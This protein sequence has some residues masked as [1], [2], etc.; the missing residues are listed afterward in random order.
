MSA[1]KPFASLK[2]MPRITRRSGVLAQ[3]QHLLQG[4]KRREIEVEEAMV[5]AQW[6]LGREASAVPE[7][8][9]AFADGLSHMRRHPDRIPL[10][11]ETGEGVAGRDARDNAARAATPNGT[12]SPPM[13]L[14]VEVWRDS[15]SGMRRVRISE[16]S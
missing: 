3:L 4:A 12:T 8:M 2:R 11:T 5:E 6:V 15:R 10:L 1:H 9:R 7:F 14:K 13:Q 16:T